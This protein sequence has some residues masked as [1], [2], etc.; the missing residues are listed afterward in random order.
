[1]NITLWS[2][3]G[4]YSDDIAGAETPPKICTDSFATE[5]NSRSSVYSSCI[6]NNKQ[7]FKRHSVIEDCRN[8]YSRLRAEIDLSEVDEVMGNVTCRYIN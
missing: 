4:K 5:I 7:L 1:M 2:P 6:C 3:L 8:V